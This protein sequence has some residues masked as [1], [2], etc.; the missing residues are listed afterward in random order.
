VKYEIFYRKGFIKKELSLPRYMVDKIPDELTPTR[1]RW[2]R[3]IPPR[4][5][6][7]SGNKVARR[8]R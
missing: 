5:E 2:E 4:I 3:R 8:G 6:K 1:K 7:Y